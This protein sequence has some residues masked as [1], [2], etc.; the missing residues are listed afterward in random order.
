MEAGETVNTTAKV[1]Y[2]SADSV[3]QPVTDENTVAW[4]R[5][6]LVKIG[7]IVAL[8]AFISGAEIGLALGLQRTLHVVL[9][10]ALILG[11]ISA[12]TATVASSSRLPTSVIS[13]FAFGPFGAKLV[14]L[15]LAVSLVGWFGVTAAI[16]GDTL[17]DITKKSVEIDLP[18]W[19][20]T[21]FGSVL[22]V[23]TAVFGFR[24]LQGVS[25]AVV[26]VML[27]ALIIVAYIAVQRGDFPDVSDIS[28]DLSIG[29]GISALVGGMIIGVT[30]FPDLA[31][32]AKSAS[33]GRLA[34]V[35][36]YSVAVPFILLLSAVPA[37]ATG[38]KELTLIMLGL[39]LGVPALAVLTF[40]AWTTNAGNVYS[41]SLMLSPLL[42]RTDRRI[43]TVGVGIVGTGAAIAGITDY[44]MQWLILLGISI[45]P[46]AGIY[47]AD[48]FLVRGRKYELQALATV[49]S[50][51]FMA[52]TAWIMGI[53]IAFSTSREVFS[54]TGIPSIDAIAVSFLLYTGLSA[55]LPKCA[56]A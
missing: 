20:F 19:S 48:F 43:L 54:L 23:G 10:S 37:V 14:N 56:V 35:A 45:P 55:I 42:E 3:H 11:L 49:N 27:A 26:P 4:W 41:A 6:A 33:Q 29:L 16:F 53:A 5:I 52:F 1:T 30:I 18:S 36:T 31:R 15:I 39:G 47:L 40:V 13:Q 24:G 9:V 12:L 44:Y 28:S 17:A 22:M 21:I 2:V 51:N 46:V 7:V 8:P 32:F 25:D 50:I 34:G 38:E